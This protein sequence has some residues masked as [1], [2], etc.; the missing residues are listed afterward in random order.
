MRRRAAGQFQRMGGPPPTSSGVYNVL[1]YTVSLET[2][3]LT[4]SPEESFAAACSQIQK[5]LGLKGTDAQALA[6]IQ[7]LPFLEQGATA[8]TIV[9]TVEAINGGLLTIQQVENGFLATPHYSR[10]AAPGIPSDVANAMPEVPNFAVDQLSISGPIASGPAVLVPIL[11]D[12]T[13]GLVG[14]LAPPAGVALAAA[15][16]VENA[17]DAQ[18]DTPTAA[19][20]QSAATQQAAA[21]SAFNQTPPAGSLATMVK[22]AP[23]SIVSAPVTASA[24]ASTAT[25]PATSSS[26]TFLLLAGGLAFLLRDSLRG[27]HA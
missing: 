1:P 19:G 20:L 23:G 4:G 12:T 14:I 18:A 8:S 27:S 7:A 5:A 3:R 25:G 22:P 15:Y 2:F 16:T 11:Q 17:N 9:A 26:L 6:V 21:Y 13:V 24:T 10:P